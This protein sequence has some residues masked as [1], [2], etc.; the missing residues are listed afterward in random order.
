MITA[1]LRSAKGHGAPRDSIC[2]GIGHILLGAGQTTAWC[3]RQLFHVL[4]LHQVHV[5]STQGYGFDWLK[6]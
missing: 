5:G 4:H 1:V 3:A 6:Q 2:V